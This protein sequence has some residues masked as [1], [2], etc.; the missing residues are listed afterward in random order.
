MKPHTYIEECIAQN[1]QLRYFS[2]LMG[3]F[4]KSPN[5]PRTNLPKPNLPNF[6]SIHT[7]QPHPASRALRVLVADDY[8][9][10]R[11]GLCAMLQSRQI[12][13]CGQAKN[14]EEAVEKSRHLS[15]ELIILDISM[16]VLGGIEA[17]QQ[18]RVFLPDVPILFYSMHNTRELI[19]IAKSVGAQGFVTK[20]QMAARLLE[21]VD[22]LR[23]KKTFF[24]F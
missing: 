3:E 17:A 14:G 12:E 21:A 8:E 7:V 15:P 16:P 10:V 1:R 22:A 24:S 13:V 6:D 20:D 23:N 18:I 2:D 19:A 5:A 9:A 4:P 11:M